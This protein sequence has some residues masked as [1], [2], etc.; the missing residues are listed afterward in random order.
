MVR[1]SWSS[2]TDD[3]DDAVRIANSS[4]YGLSA[5]VSSGSIERAASIANRLR[6][7]TVSVN[8]ST[9]F[10]VDSPFGGYKQSGLGRRGGATG[11]RRILRKQDNK[12]PG[13]G[14]PVWRARQVIDIGAVTTGR[15]H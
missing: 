11:I 1:W 10:A 9:W 3:D 6:A 14:E 8:G 15:E 7:G 5:A 12:F 4:M 13:V 2:P